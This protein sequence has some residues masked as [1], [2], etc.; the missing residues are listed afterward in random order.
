MGKSI[1]DKKDADDEI[2]HYQAGYFETQEILD[3]RTQGVTMRV[4]KRL[5]L[6]C[7]R[8]FVS[9]G[10]CHRICDVCKKGHVFWSD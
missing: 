6:N 8:A 3:K 5:C 2:V 7:D 4:K 10:V 1:Y 9:I